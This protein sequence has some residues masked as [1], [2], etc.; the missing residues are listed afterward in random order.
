VDPSGE[1][2]STQVVQLLSDLLAI[3]SN[4]KDLPAPNVIAVVP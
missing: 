1:D 4:A 2:A 3:Q